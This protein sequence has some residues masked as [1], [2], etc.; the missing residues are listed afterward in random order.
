[1]A[2]K[3]GDFIW[4]EL[5]TSNADAATAFYQAVLGWT[6]PKA[7]AG[8]PDY[9]MIVTAAGNAGGVL[10]LTPSMIAG[11]ARPAWVGYIG[12]DDVDKMVAAIEQSGGS[13]L[14]P[15]QQLAGVGRF[16]MVADPQGAPFYI[17]H[18]ASNETSTCFAGDM[19]VIGHCA[20]NELYANDPA[21]ALSFYTTHFGWRKDGELDMGALGKYEFLRHGGMIGALMPKPPH[22]PVGAWNF[23]F[24]VA[25][26]D[27]AAKSVG[28]NGGRVLHG[29]SQV[30]GG[31]WAMNALD[32]QGASFA[33]VGKQ[34]G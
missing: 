3:H 13:V 18:A 25:D 19:P 28:A 9:R 16:A 29:P 2:N 23:Y 20:W 7:Q 30:P 1:M 24:R 34:V 32:P 11:G 22:V 17:M 4:Y 10:P 12:V 6:I 26:I 15:A 31:D 8:A 5:M 33:L 14:M 21:Q 27:L